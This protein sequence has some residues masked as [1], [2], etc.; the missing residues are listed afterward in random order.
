M[1][2]KTKV[3]LLAALLTGGCSVASGPTY[4]AYSID[5]TGGEKTFRVECNG[6]FEGPGTCDRKAQQICDEQPVWPIESV[7]PLGTMTSDGK[8]NARILTFRCGARTATPAAV[9]P[10]APR[11]TVAPQKVT[12]NGDANFDTAKWTLRPDARMR[13]DKLI[14]DAHGVTFG[15]VEVKGFTDS[16]GSDAYNVTLSERRANAVATYLRFHGLQARNFSAEGCGKV[17][18]V[19]TNATADGRSQNRRVEIRLGQ[20]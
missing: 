3:V 1:L 2:T 18:P 5:R 6:L 11:P 9:A 10:L 16:V 7:G 8:P 15:T 19:A 20:N 4:N 14:E 13:L 12:L 17:D